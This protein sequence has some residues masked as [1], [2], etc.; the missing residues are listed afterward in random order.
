M[1]FGLSPTNLQF[2]TLAGAGIERRGASL[3]FP[4]PM[5]VAHRAPT[6]NAAEREYKAYRC[7][8][9][10]P[11]GGAGNSGDGGGLGAGGPP[12]PTSRRMST[13]ALSSAPKRNARFE[14]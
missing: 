13:I 7:A 4:S 14:M 10:A 2:T 5:Q 12:R 6:P 3:P 9:P 8:S 1:F 11:S